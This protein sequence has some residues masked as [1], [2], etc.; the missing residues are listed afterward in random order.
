MNIKNRFIIVVAIFHALVLIGF[1][2]AGA[3]V[4]LTILFA[5]NFLSNPNFVDLVLI[6]A[7]RL[8]ALGILSLLGY[9]TLI[10]AGLNKGRRRNVFY[11]LAITILWWS[12]A[13]LIVTRDSWEIIYSHP[14][15]YGPFLIIS[16]APIFWESLKS[17]VSSWIKIKSTF[18]GCNSSDSN[19]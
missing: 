3:V 12:V 14:L 6:K 19:L 2:H 13:Y 5:P 16:L 17:R 4:G 7:D 18:I 10:I 11:L 1:G 9:L 15:F 8:P